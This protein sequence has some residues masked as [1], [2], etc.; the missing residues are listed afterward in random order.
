M[1]SASA[2]TE[3]LRVQDWHNLAYWTQSE[4]A[5]GLTTYRASRI[6]DPSKGT[7]T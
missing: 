5:G 6:D 2:I 3:S 7:G 4:G 1:K